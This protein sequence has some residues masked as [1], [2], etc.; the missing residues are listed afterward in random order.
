LVSER[1]V[2]MKL[3]SLGEKIT[4]LNKIVRHQDYVS[5]LVEVS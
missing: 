3:R 5:N 2:D 1:D 4:A